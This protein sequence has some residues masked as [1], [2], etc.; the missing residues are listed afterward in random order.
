MP[1]SIPFAN[2]ALILVAVCS[3]SAA[4]CGNSLKDAANDAAGVFDGRASEL[5]YKF[6]DD[7]CREPLAL[8][9]IG[10]SQRTSFEFSGLSMTRNEQYFS[11]EDCK[12]DVAID[13]YYR[14]KYSQGDEVQANVHPIDLSYDSVT[15]VPRNEAG[16]K[17]LNTFDFCGIT[18]WT[19]DREDNVTTV[20][21]DAKCPAEGTPKNV[22]DL[23]SMKDDVLV[24]GK[25]KDSDK[26]TPQTRATELN[27]ETTYRRVN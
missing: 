27:L 14:G 2:T 13:V 24:F 15:V 7:T 21:R 22:F 26:A 25:G 9:I 18:D 8:K 10:A 3:L 11:E 23:Y 20:S 5:Q 19:V 4:G 17:V 16:V 12:G 6:L 1:K